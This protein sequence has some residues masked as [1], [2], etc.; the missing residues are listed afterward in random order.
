MKGLF[1]IIITDIFQKFLVK[2]KILIRIIVLIS[3]KEVW[4]IMIFL[5]KLIAFLISNLPILMKIKKN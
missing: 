5:N 3:S 1:N 4:K 2:V